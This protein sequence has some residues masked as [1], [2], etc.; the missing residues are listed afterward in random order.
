MRFKIAFDFFCF[1]LLMANLSWSWEVNQFHW[2]KSYIG[3]LLCGMSPPNK[4]LNE[5]GSRSECVSSCFHV[6]PSPC[7]AVNYWKNARLCQ[8]F[9]YIPCS[10]DVQQDCINYQVTIMKYCT[11]EIVQFYKLV[12]LISGQFLLSYSVMIAPFC[13]T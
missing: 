11:F 8:Q 1:L 13:I 5:V 10:Y 7:Q 4:T 3:E 12:F 9:H 6:C 2:V